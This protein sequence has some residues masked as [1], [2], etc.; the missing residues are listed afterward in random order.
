MKGDPNFDV[1]PEATVAAGRPS[2]SDLARGRAMQDEVVKEHLKEG[3]AKNS[4]QSSAD[5]TNAQ[6]ALSEQ[7]HKVGERIGDSLDDLGYT[8]PLPQE[9][10]TGITQD[11]DTEDE[12]MENTDSSGQIAAK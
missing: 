9:H 6:I 7:M 8:I 3:I 5:Q 12:A 10:P 11:E 1:H 4:I 2:E